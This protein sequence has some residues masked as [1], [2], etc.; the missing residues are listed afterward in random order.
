M[1]AKL[2][3]S[4]EYTE[5]NRMKETFKRQQNRREQFSYLCWNF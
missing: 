1:K 5:T 2:S 4:I 3:A